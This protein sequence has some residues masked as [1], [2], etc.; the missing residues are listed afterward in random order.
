MAS[1]VSRVSQA[2]PRDEL[3][4][5]A[6]A[7]AT[8]EWVSRTSRV[9]VRVFLLEG[10][11]AWAVSSKDR[12]QLTQYLVEKHGV[13]PSVVRSII[14]ECQR[15]SRS[16]SEVVIERKIATHEDVRR[17][18][19]RQVLVAL[20]T[21]DE[22]TSPEI[23]FNARRLKYPLDLT[24]SLSEIRAAQEAMK[25]EVM[26]PPASRPS[27]DPQSL[28]LIVGGS[29][30]NPE[31]PAPSLEATAAAPNP[32]PAA[33]A[34]KDDPSSNTTSIITKRESQEMATNIQAALDKLR[35][36]D[37]FV[38]ASLVDSESGML[39]GSE[40]GG[41]AI[42]LEI[43]GAANTEVVR[44]KRKAVKALNL[45][46]DIE[47]ILISLGKQYHLIRLLKNRP[48]VFFYVVLDRTRANLALA[49]M[50]LADAERA[51]DL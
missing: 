38:G 34:R 28:T 19:L 36:V 15:A 42:N 12:A 20:A 6:D 18:L 4:R 3:G 48:T 31:A 46:D 49:R 50:S 30:A 14:E 41:A 22:M 16:F 23:S 35:T 29:P 9:E 8:G 51:F 21:L 26:P 37:G 5:L 25:D 1:S 33:P 32:D 43:A 10:R 45:K 24:F 2:S 11:V 39:L 27:V 17:M 44:A 13:V 7:E 47:D 40:G